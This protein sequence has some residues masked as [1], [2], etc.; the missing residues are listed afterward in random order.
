MPFKSEQAKTSLKKLERIY[1]FFTIQTLGGFFV[2]LF[3][4]LLFFAFVVVFPCGAGDE[5]QN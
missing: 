2:Y 5:T 1:L 4:F 3:L